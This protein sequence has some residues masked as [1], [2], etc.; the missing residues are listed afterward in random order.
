MSGVGAEF[1]SQS[2]WATSTLRKLLSEFLPG[3]SLDK[4]QVLSWKNFE[5][6]QHQRILH[7]LKLCTCALLHLLSAWTSSASPWLTGM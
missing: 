4:A 7:C 1:S 2:L 5:F 6:T 3:F